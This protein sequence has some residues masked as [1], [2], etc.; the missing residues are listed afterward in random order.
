MPSYDGDSTEHN[1]GWKPNN[2]C[3]SNKDKCNKVNVENEQRELIAV[4]VISDPSGWIQLTVRVMCGAGAWP[5]WTFRVSGS[6]WPVG[7][8]WIRPR[9]Q[10][11]ART[12]RAI[13]SPVGRFARTAAPLGQSLSPP[14]NAVLCVRPVHITQLPDEYHQ[15]L[16]FFFFL[17]YFLYYY[18]HY[19]SISI[20]IYI[21]IYI[22][23]VYYYTDWDFRTFFL[24]FD[25][26]MIQSC[27]YR[28]F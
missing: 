10:R 11:V 2:T 28:I 5:K 18:Y 8:T 16:F 17:N 19:Y 14:T 26:Y 24:K 4:L 13:C 7:R 27:H 15:T 12:W 9:R 21:Y 6:Y 22:Y 23:P 3:I 25:F 1:P 20:N